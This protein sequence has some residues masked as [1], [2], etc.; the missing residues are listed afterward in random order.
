M[1]KKYVIEFPDAAT[2]LAVVSAN[3]KAYATGTLIWAVGDGTMH[4]VTAPGIVSNAI[5]TAP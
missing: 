3:P 4:I 5:S 2:A 1:S